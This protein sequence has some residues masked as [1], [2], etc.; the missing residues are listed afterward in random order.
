MKGGG[1]DRERE[2]PAGERLQRFL[3]RCGAAS[4]RRAEE[5]IVAGRVSVNGRVVR[6]LGTK[7]DPQRDDVRLDGRRLRPEPPVYLLLHKPRGVLTTLRDP[8][9]RPT[10]AELVRDV[11][12]RVFPVGRLDWDSS[13]L[14]L[15]TNDGELAAR[16]MHPRYGVTK[17]YR[18]TVTGLVADADLERLRRGVRLQEGTV[19]PV[20]VRVLGRRGGE[21]LL[22]VTLR[23]GRYREVR[24]LLAALGYEVRELVRVQEGP[25]RLGE[26]TPGSVRPLTDG[27]I[28]RLRAAVGLEPM[29]RE[30]GAGAA[31]GGRPG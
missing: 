27:E 20:A 12:A 2:R 28:R 31:K 25:I 21:T 19:R 13:G 14:L 9:G 15:M 30:F 3:A 4:R 1:G 29:G 6:E 7:V 17:V 26:L 5:L 23:E 11:G 8:Q 18:V 24:R 10:V 16:L 22:E